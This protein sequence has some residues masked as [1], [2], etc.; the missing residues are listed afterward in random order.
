MIISIIADG[1]FHNARLD[2]LI[3]FL[4]QHPAISTDVQFHRNHPY[5]NKLIYYGRNQ[6]EKPDGYY[7]PAQ[8]M[9]LSSEKSPT[10]P[11]FIANKY[12]YDGSFLYSV[13]TGK[14][15]VQD[16]IQG[17]NFAFD[18]FETIFFHITRYEE[19]FA[20]KILKDSH[21]YLLEKHHFLVRNKLQREPIVDHLVQ[22]LAKVLSIIKSKSYSA[23]LTHDL[24]AIDKYPNFY[25][26]IKLLAKSALVNNQANL[27][28]LLKQYSQIRSNRHPDPYDTFD[29]LFTKARG[30]Q[31]FL[32]ILAGG[33]TKYEGFYQLGHPDVQK[34]I[35]LALDRGYTI[36]LH[37]SYRTF[38]D[39]KMMTVEKT[40]LEEHLGLEIIHSRQHWL[41]F[42]ILETPLILEKCGIRYDHSMGYQNIVGFRA[43]TGCSYPWYSLKEERI[44]NLW[45]N[46]FVLMDSALVAETKGHA[47]NMLEM[48][49]SMADKCRDR[50]EMNINFHN[51]S[52]DKLRAGASGAL[53]CYQY[54]IDQMTRHE[55]N[56]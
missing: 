21:G 7:I 13:A 19:A 45:E 30:M 32:F 20:N 11:T 9:M 27:F 39:L 44:L 4:N 29:W 52:F 15:A 31:K 14:N 48:V 37:P 56:R 6:P 50:S 54:L 55:G 2:Y 41:R 34:I 3:S 49:R 23:S 16:F 8:G 38:T 18:V 47:E 40:N 24:D 51:S 42:D 25:K 26:F 43:A 36:G 33:T 17:E 10:S 5:P 1:N 22:A 35:S 53:A 46:P 12:R 28:D